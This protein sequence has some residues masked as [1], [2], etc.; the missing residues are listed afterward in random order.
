MVLVVDKTLNYVRSNLQ[1]DG[2]PKS[3]KIQASRV[4]I[5]HDGGLS[6]FNM[7]AIGQSKTV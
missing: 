4:F 6:M 7:K 2:V 3:I 5:A 1:I